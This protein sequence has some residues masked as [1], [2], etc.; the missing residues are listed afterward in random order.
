MRFMNPVE[1]KRGSSFK[2]LATYLLHDVKSDTSERVGWTQSY[3]LNDAD[4]DRAWRLMA[5]TAKSAEAL[6]AAAGEAK[7][8]AKVHKPVYHFTL[9][10]SGS[11]QVSNGLQQTAV[12]EALETLK[13]NGHQALA[14]QHTDDHPHVHVMVNLVNPENGTVPKLSYTQKNLRKWANKFEEKHGLKITQGSRLNEQKRQRGEQVDARRK[15]RNIYEQQK[16]EGKNPRLQWL[17]NQEQGLAKNLQL[18]NRELKERHSTEWETLKQGFYA[19]KDALETAREEDI[20]TTITDTK[21][22]YKPR[23][24]ALFRQ[25]REAIKKFEAGENSTVSKIVNMGRSF[26]AARREGKS[27]AGSFTTSAREDGRRHY[28]DKENNKR[29][30]ALADELQSNISSNIK[31]IKARH[32]AN[33]NK[34]RTAYLEQCKA[35]SKTQKDE[36][37]QQQQK[38]REYRQRRQQNYQRMSSA[39]QQQSRKQGRGKGYGQSLEPR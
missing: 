6:K 17:K 38:W 3:N 24:A 1:L 36:R 37:R 9:T 19:Q 35:L 4:G 20:Q 27:I 2:G 29:Q 32:N 30:Q 31:G 18:E 23:W 11:D 8:G 26:L 12:A 14:V 13:L 7:T 39:R 33:M 10:W 21:A 22:A 34:A 5:C 28:V 16:A 15:P 25:N